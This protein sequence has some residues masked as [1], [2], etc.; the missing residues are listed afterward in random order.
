MP[1]Y[2]QAQWLPEALDALLAQSFNDWECIIVSDGSPDDVATIAGEYVQIDNRISFYDTKNGGVSVARNFAIQQAKAPYILPLD[3]DDKIS[4]NYIEACFK[5]IDN[6][7]EIKVAYG[8]A[9][10]FGAINGQWR[11][12]DYSF[13]ELL[14]SNIIHPCGMFRKADWEQINGYDEQMLD[15]IEDWEFWINLLKD[16]GKAVRA[17][18]AVFYWRRKEESRTTKITTEKSVRLQRYIYFKHATLYERHF[19]D[20]IALYN[21]YRRVYENWKWIQDN[22]FRFFISRLKKKNHSK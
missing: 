22:P 3:A 13:D 1:A 4:S 8:A 2:N 16:G 18:D 11:L 9:E 6:S 17:N 12:P 19:T 20:P 10:K 21:G 7:A 5:I 15:G 14:L